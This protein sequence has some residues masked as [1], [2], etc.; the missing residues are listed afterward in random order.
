MRIIPV[1]FCFLLCEVVLAEET[2]KSEAKPLLPDLREI[3][4]A[5][6]Y[7]GIYSLLAILD[8][9]GIRSNLEEL[10]TPEFVGSFKGSSNKELEKAA[11]KCGLHAKTYSGLT[12]QELKTSETPMIL[13]FR[14]TSSSADFNHWVAYLGVDGG[15]AR[16]ID[17]PHRLTTIP[18]AELLAKWNGT[19]IVISQEPIQDEV[20]IASSSSYLMT[21]VLILGVLF[22]LKAF[23][24]N[25][26]KEAFVAP[27][28]FQKCKLG[29]TQSV[30]F[31]LSNL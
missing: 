10:L 23:Y 1:L 17:L 3:V 14:S 20:L 9:F 27:T 12:W 7:C 22:A 6:P 13:H 2:P 11:E 16:I 24:W 4:V 5:G 26:Q 18:F 21:V 29:V 8:T 30:V 31:V 25:P 19:A 28:L 15:Q